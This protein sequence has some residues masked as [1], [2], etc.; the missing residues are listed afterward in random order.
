MVGHPHVC[1]QMSL[2]GLL[3]PYTI[4][5]FILQAAL[6]SMVVVA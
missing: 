4:M 3:S 1:S 2:S 5:L 6:V